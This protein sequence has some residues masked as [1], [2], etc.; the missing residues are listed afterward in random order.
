MKEGIKAAR[1]SA[2]IVDVLEVFTPII[3]GVSLKLLHYHVTQHK[4]YGDD[5]TL[6]E[7]ATAAE[8]LA[9][10]ELITKTEAYTLR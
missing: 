9:R 1:L 7:V 2:A 3:G 6:E 4:L 8:E 5:Y 10:N